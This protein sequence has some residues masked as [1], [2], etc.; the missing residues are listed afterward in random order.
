MD[1]DIPGSGHNQPPEPTPFERWAELVDN[2]NVWSTNVPKISSKEQAGRAQ[3]FVD[4][5]RLTT[6]DVEAEW[7]KEREPFD[8]EIAML[9]TKYRAPLELLGIALD[10]MKAL[11]KDWLDR[12]TARLDHEA[13]ER[14]RRAA[15]AE[16]A[17]LKARQEA[18][19]AGA[20][21]EAEAKAR[22]A[23]EQAE[24]ALALAAKPV[25]RARIKGEFSAKAM[26]LHVYWK[27]V[28]FDEQKALK[29]FAKHPAIREAALAAI[30]KLETKHA[31]KV[32]D[33]A[34]APPG[35]RFEKEER[36]V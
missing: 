27:A 4:Q 24:T 8:I 31:G 35:V 11:T 7:K 9:R 34:Q 26:S 32:K 6:E 15:E 2:C 36:P 3:A 20:S 14:K 16:A 21:V 10:K 1:T 13:A 29:H 18:A 25:E 5:L 19:R 22:H 12:E 33:A 23:E 17:A 30:V 28:V